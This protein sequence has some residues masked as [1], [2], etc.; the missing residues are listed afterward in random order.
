MN[1]KSAHGFLK[2]WSVNAF[3]VKAVKNDSVWSA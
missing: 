3:C 1:D 2:M